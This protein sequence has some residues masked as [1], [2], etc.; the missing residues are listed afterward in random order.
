MLSEESR[1]SETGEKTEELVR[2][3]DRGE[4]REDGGETTYHFEPLQ[5]RRNVLGV[6]ISFPPTV[7]AV[8][9]W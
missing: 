8:R 7:Y 2:R 4:K 1:E 6:T 9:G 3:G 5:Q